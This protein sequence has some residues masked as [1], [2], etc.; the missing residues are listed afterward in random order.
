MECVRPL[1]AQGCEL[2]GPVLLAKTFVFAR[3]PHGPSNLR[4]LAR[5]PRELTALFPTSER[6][7]ALVY[8]DCSDSRSR[9]NSAMRFSDL[10]MNFRHSSTSTSRGGSLASLVCLLQLR[11][12]TLDSHSVSVPH[13]RESLFDF[14][15]L[16]TSSFAIAVR[17]HAHCRGSRTCWHWVDPWLTRIL[18]GLCHGPL[19]RKRP[20][21]TENLD[22]TRG[23]PRKGSTLEVPDGWLQVIR[24]PRPPAVR[25]PKAPRSWTGQATEL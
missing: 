7:L 16:P 9:S 12:Q 15:H 22:P 2:L 25:W 23:M 10:T 17:I 21:S 5:L 18:H 3:F 4:E 1:D 6:A 14:H 13:Y 19:L 8:A 24:G 20:R 11:L